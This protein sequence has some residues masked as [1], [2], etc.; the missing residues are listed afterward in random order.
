MATLPRLS[1]ANGAFGDRQKRS[2]PSKRHKSACPAEL[3]AYSTAQRMTVQLANV[4]LHGCNVIC[5]QTELRQGQI[6]ELS[7]AMGG[8]IAGI[9]RWT[10][11][12]QAGLEFMRPISPDT[13]RLISE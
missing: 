5:R 1:G 3:I 2:E 7:L 8:K 6:V 13:M 12:D 10:G 11:T 9:V 4:S